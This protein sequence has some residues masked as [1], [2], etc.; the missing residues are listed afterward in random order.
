MSFHKSSDFTKKYKTAKRAKKHDIVC[1][2]CGDSIKG[3]VRALSDHQ[4]QTVKRCNFCYTAIPAIL[5]ADHV[6][7]C[8]Q[9]AENKLLELE[10]RKS[11]SPDARQS[12]PEIVPEN[13]AEVRNEPVA[14]NVSLPVAENVCL[15]A[16]ENV[17]DN[18]EVDRDLPAQIHP[19][20]N[21]SQSS[22]SSE[23]CN[24]PQKL[25]SQKS[26]SEKSSSQ[27]SSSSQ[28]YDTNS[29][30][31]IK[32]HDFF[33]QQYESRKINDVKKDCHD[34]M[35]TILEKSILE[36][37]S[38]LTSQ[39]SS[40]RTRS[41]SR[42]LR[43]D[44]ESSNEHF[45]PD[46]TAKREF[47]KETLRKSHDLN[48][49]GADLRPLLEMYKYA[50]SNNEK[51]FLCASILPDILTED[52]ET[53][54][55][56]L[57]QTKREF[58]LEC[59]KERLL[60]MSEGRSYKIE[61]HRCN[62][63]Q[64]QIDEQLK[65]SIIAKLDED[66]QH[67]PGIQERMRIRCDS[68]RDRSIL[69]FYNSNENI[70]IVTN[71]RNIRC[72]ESSRKVLP[73]RLTQYF[74]DFVKPQ[75]PKLSFNKFRQ[76]VPYYIFE[77]HVGWSTSCVCRHCSNF[78]YGVELLNKLG[79]EKDIV[80]IQNLKF[81]DFLTKHVCNA[82]DYFMT[83]NC[84]RKRLHDY[85]YGHIKKV[86]D[87]QQCQ[88]SCQSKLMEFVLNACDGIDLDGDVRF[89]RLA[90]FG[91]DRWLPIKSS[92]PQSAMRSD[93]ALKLAVQMIADSLDHKHD[94]EKQKLAKIK[95]NFKNEEYPPAGTSVLSMDHGS[96]VSLSLPEQGQREKLQKSNTI[97]N[98]TC[99]WCFASYGSQDEIVSR[100]MVVGHFVSN[101]KH[102]RAFY[103]FAEN[104]LREYIR[105]NYKD[106][107][108]DIDKTL[109]V[110]D[111]C[112]GEQKNKFFLCSLKFASFE[113]QVFFKVSQH[114]K[115]QSCNL[116]L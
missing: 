45:Q 73:I 19:T 112:S 111:N 113:R 63:G 110:L 50:S 95:W 40:V 114:S 80:A 21:Q 42:L 99:E 74:N 16:A 72:F 59:H 101:I 108:I 36:T 34:K 47:L 38:I 87:C 4:C 53:Y 107:R 52:D 12:P 66:S 104:K 22:S 92:D 49:I 41:Q 13:V 26:S 2:Q 28:G 90:Q 83:L 31:D 116:S 5:F 61:S 57:F 97:I 106:S 39:K 11:D 70:E 30:P 27:K 105:Q 10:A 68:I 29:D 102:N 78:G 89:A 93:Q 103:Y 51:R 8:L 85:C 84:F 23:K 55:A 20:P 3:N 7:S 82:S 69:E 56:A 91:K 109:I 100:H 25:S 6:Q 24:P 9:L 86:S 18:I 35:D 14:E 81:E 115:D 79:A 15:S 17:L 46:S 88:H 64:I 67:W 60:K 75:H 94:V 54:F 76:L 71:K 98:L 48:D 1:P 43:Q 62:L 33:H 37:R 32:R 77:C 58:I 65:K 96:P 44:S